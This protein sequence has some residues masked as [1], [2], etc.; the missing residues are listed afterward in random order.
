MNNKLISIL[1][2]LTILI[3]S[4]KKLEK[5]TQ[6]NLAF[7]ESI[8][9]P[10]TSGI[11]LPFNILTPEISSNSEAAFE[12]NDTRKDLI[13]KINLFKMTLTLNTPTNGNFDFLKNIEL[14]INADGL[15]ETRIS[16]KLDMA[17]ENKKQINLEVSDSDLKEYIKKDKFTLRCATTTDEA[18]S[19]D[20][21]I[22]V[23]YV[24]FVD[25]KLKK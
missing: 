4:C 13:E 23:N 5:L 2:L 8:T 7:N 10:A 22:D 6:F 11:N 21:N 20:H 1:I 3:S 25:A 18:I 24:F 14:F 19:Q 15:N 9:I 16:Y 17:N 12:I